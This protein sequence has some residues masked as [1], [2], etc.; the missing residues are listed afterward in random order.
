MREKL[1]KGCALCI[2]LIIYAYSSSRRAKRDT[3]EVPPAKVT[4]YPRGRGIPRG[5]VP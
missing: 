5:E 2:I 3:L 4:R 1:L